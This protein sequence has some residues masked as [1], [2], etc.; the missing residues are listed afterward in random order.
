MSSDQYLGTAYIISPKDDDGEILDLYFVVTEG[1]YLLHM[2]KM[3]KDISSSVVEA[4]LAKLLNGLVKSDGRYNE[5]IKNPK[6]YH[7]R[8]GIV[9]PLTVEDARKMDEMY[10]LPKAERIRKMKENMDDWAR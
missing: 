6:A 8:M 5:F 9:P 4:E 10:R 3:S 2:E 1:G 7:I